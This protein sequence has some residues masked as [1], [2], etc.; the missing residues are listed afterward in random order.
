MR[1]HKNILRACLLYVLV[2][3]TATGYPLS[4]LAAST[5]PS[6]TS[7]TV[8]TPVPV[9]K[10]TYTLNPDTNHWDSNKWK[11]DP[12]TGTYQRP[13]APAP[14]IITTPETPVVAGAGTQASID[15]V[16]PS[17]G[18]SST[19]IT[20]QP[21]SSTTTAQQSTVGVENN[22]TSQSQ[23]GN[24][25][26]T[27]NTTGGNAT[28]GDATATSTVV[29]AVHSTVQ[30]DTAGIAHFSAD[31][32][33]NVVGDITLAPAL[34]DALNKSG[35]TPSSTTTIQAD[36]ATSLTNNISLGAVSGN[37]E[38]IDNTTA[39][40]AT[41]G[42]ANTVAN[43][44]NLINSI[45]AANKSFVGTI[46]IYGNLDGDILVSPDFIP[47]LLA[48]NVPVVDA[49]DS[50]S[51]LG[52]ND[53]QSIVNNVTL[54]AAS[55]SANV[56]NN[57]KAGN[58][59]SGTA[60]TNLTIL[61]YTGHQVV[62]SNSLLIFVNVL[63]RWVGIIVDAPVGATAAV[64]GNGVTSNTTN[65]GTQTVD[66]NATTTITNNIDLASLSGDATVKGNTQA[67]NATSGYATASANIAN[68]STSSFSISDW[69]GVL[70]INVFGTWYGSFGVDTANGTV[71]PITGGIISPAP[72]TPTAVTSIPQFGFKPRETTR[73]TTTATG[74]A[75]ISPIDELTTAEAVS[76]VTAAPAAIIEGDTAT[77]IV[78]SESAQPNS[79]SMALVIASLISA[80][81]AAGI[82]LYRKQDI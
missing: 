45:I 33:G 6:A 65:G 9:P 2:V 63:G 53:T 38:V 42:T 78:I 23:T 29:N 47:Q 18:T 52:I 40:N 67:G 22:I 70:F 62:A 75:N 41:T 55:G 50:P 82:G 19:T 31:I 13:P 81:V 15:P 27:T 7:S 72:A 26:V 68:I 80:T 24:A 5:D 28:S 39:G 57:T 12:Q 30:G 76:A 8:V 35:S 60:A 32:H 25:G 61:N 36:Q 44:I 77:P 74:P 54:N 4:A 59:T 1:N 14:P 73:S 58:A 37:S 3:I 66:A 17:A 51:V 10:E 43:V 69:F 79:I 48:S 16:S 20:Q 49:S 71:T 46:N 11:Y 34:D 56:L 21:A 64:L